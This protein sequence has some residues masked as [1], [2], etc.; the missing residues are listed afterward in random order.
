V[1]LSAL[2][3]SLPGAQ[4]CYYNAVAHLSVG[5]ALLL[6]YLAPVPVIGWLVELSGSVPATLRVSLT[7]RR[8]TNRPS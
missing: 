5:V 1:P 8:G 7:A 3:S 2:A 4:L 6:A